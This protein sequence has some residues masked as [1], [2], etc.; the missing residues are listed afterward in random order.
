M[1]SGLVLTAVLML[2]VLIVAFLYLDGKNKNK[3]KQQRI[4]QTEQANNVQSRYKVDVVRLVEQLELSPQARNKLMMIGNNYFVYQAISAQ[5][6]ESL[7]YNL[8]K[9]SQLFSDLQDDFKLHGEDSAAI[10]K[11][12]SF[13]EQLPQGP[14]GFNGGFYN[15]NLSVICQLLTITPVNNELEEETEQSDADELEVA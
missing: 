1:L 10:D 15:T 7:T 11:I 2:A 3:E 12:D 4:E 8:D 14:R 6:V 5:T 13:V 9:L